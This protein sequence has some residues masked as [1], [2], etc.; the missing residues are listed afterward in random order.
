MYKIH[1]LLHVSGISQDS[2]LLLDFLRSETRGKSR[3]IPLV[4]AADCP[5][6]CSSLCT[7]T[8]NTHTHRRETD[9]SCCCCWGCVSVL[10]V[11]YR[12]TK[13]WPGAVLFRWR[14]LTSINLTHSEQHRCCFTPSNCPK[15][16]QNEQNH[17]C[18]THQ[19]VQIW[20]EMSKIADALPTRSPKFGR[21]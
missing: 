3:E 14:S 8:S 5:L 13:V 6:Q 19:T 17:W 20:M 18:F 7:S 10:R 4:W 11:F 1:F 9:E 15:L 12:P 21:K 16:V 2:C